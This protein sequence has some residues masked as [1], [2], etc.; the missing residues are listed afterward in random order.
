MVV[1]RVETPAAGEKHPELLCVSRGEAFPPRGTALLLPA[2]RQVK[3]KSI[4]SLPQG[5]NLVTVKGAPRRALHEGAILVAGGSGLYRGQTGYGLLSTRL[6]PGRYRLRGG[7]Y[8]GCE[9]PGS[10]QIHPSNRACR[11]VATSDLPLVPGGRYQILPAGGERGP[12]LALPGA[13][14]DESRPRPAGPGR[15]RTTVDPL[16]GAELLLVVPAEVEGGLRVRLLRALDRLPFDV[17]RPAIFGLILAYQGWVETP[18]DFEGRAAL[19]GVAISETITV[20]ESFFANLTKRMVRIVRGRGGAAPR[21][22]GAA[23]GVPEGLAAAAGEALIQRGLL[24]EE[25]GLL[26]PPGGELPLSPYDRSIYAALRAGGL[27][28]RPRESVRGEQERE[29]FA[30][31]ERLGL[32][33]RLGGSWVA[34]DLV[35]GA[36]RTL[37]LHEGS[38]APFTLDSVMALLKVDRGEAL[39]LLGRLT[40]EGAL[41]RAGERW[42]AP[43]RR[44]AKG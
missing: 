43:A 15:A 16:R 3:I 40:E 39:G 44:G 24:R 8:R 10:V 1:R 28:G 22:V 27:R 32:V 12:E 20:S 38:G 23:L 14:R 5:R 2:F 26:L 13:T 17:D 37:F 33:Q 36:G 7:L 18:A 31:L 35:E 42:R 34:S 11:F 6:P 19:A 30:R 41:E 9:L 25:E 4:K 21:E 29:L